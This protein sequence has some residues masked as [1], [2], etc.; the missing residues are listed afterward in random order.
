MQSKAAIGKHPIHSALV[1]I[2][3]GAFLLALIGDISTTTVGDPI[4]F[5]F[6]HYCIG[7][8]I[9]AALL[10]AIFGSVDYFAVKMTPYAKKLATTY[11]GL[12]LVAVI[13]YIIDFFLRTNNAVFQSDQWTGVMG[14]EAIALI[15]LAISG[16][17]GG[18]M[19]YVYRVG[20][21]EDS[22]STDINTRRAA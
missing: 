6:S 11:M 5:K 17:I 4:W 18:Q 20:V 2:P 3:I 21:V 19:A 13:L 15:I 14:L 9:L 10:A 7:I 1:T 16:W 8:G 12:N 22:E